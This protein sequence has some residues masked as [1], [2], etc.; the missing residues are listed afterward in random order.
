MEGRNFCRVQSFWFPTVGHNY[1]FPVG[2]LNR[3]F[4]TPLTS[5]YKY[6][7]QNNTGHLK[8]VIFEIFK[9]N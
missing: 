6:V 3:G 1:R 8:L 5:N 9:L 2:S 4:S 7:I